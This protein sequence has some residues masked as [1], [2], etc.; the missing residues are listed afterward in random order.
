MV[1]S[2]VSA[3]KREELFIQKLRQCYVLFDFS[4]PLSDMKWKEVK[5]NA[6]HEIDEYLANEQNV[7]TEKIYPEALNMVI[8]HFYFVTLVR[9]TL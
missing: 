6:L 3:D 1:F 8:C 7:I 5:R 4:V 9:L 2:E